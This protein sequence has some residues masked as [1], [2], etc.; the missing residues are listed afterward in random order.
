M[1][2]CMV[3]VYTMSLYMIR[4]HTDLEV[5]FD[6]G[7]SLGVKQGCSLKPTH[8]LFVMKVC[9][10]SPERTITEKSK[11]HFRTNTRMEGENGGK[12]SGTDW[13][14]QGEF[15]FSFWASLYA[16]DAAT[17]FATRAS[18]L[19]ATNRIYDHLRLFGLLIDCPQTPWTVL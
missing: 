1:D 17:P 18:L 4:V 11:M 16:D 10:E 7:C 19:T 12:V 8:F 5:K 3:T 6:L 2:V 15:E 9:L 13:T 14:N